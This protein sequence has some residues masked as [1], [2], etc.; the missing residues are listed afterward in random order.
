MDLLVASLALDAANDR[1]VVDS[2]G[3]AYHKGKDTSL[4]K[5]CVKIISSSGSLECRRGNFHDQ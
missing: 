5:C 4:I 1:E 3:S 2:D